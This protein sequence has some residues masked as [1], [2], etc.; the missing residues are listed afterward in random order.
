M[1]LVHR[2][3]EPGVESTYLATLEG[4]VDPAVGQIVVLGN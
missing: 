1:E 2:Q 4:Q 3:G